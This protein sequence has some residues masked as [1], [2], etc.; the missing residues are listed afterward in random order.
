MTA[1]PRRIVDFPVTAPRMSSNK[2][3]CRSYLSTSLHVSF[4]RP[5]L[6][7]FGSLDKLHA[8]RR[9]DDRLGCSHRIVCLNLDLTA[10]QGSSRLSVVYTQRCQSLSKKPYNSFTD[11]DI[12]FQDNTRHDSIR[13]DANHILSVEV[14]GI[15]EFGSSATAIA[16]RETYD[17]Y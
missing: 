12:N 4:F 2:Q 1:P 10:L 7:S 11:A 8:T 16:S 15:G 3:R 14:S 6:A 5:V 13:P 17:H 9:Q